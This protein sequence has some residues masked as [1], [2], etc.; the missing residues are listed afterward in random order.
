[1]P[2]LQRFLQSSAYLAFEEKLTRI[3]FKIMTKRFSSL[4]QAFLM[5]AL[6]SVCAVGCSEKDEPGIDNGSNGG[7]NSEI[8]FSLPSSVDVVVGED[9]RIDVANCPVLTSDQIYLEKD[10]KLIAC[11]VTEAD[12]THFCF[13]LPSTAEAATYTLYVKRGDRRVKI[14]T[15]V[16]NLVAYKIDIKEDT[17]I[18]GVVETKEGEGIPNVVV[19]DGEETTLTDANGVYQLKSNKGQGYVFISVPSGYECELNGVFPDHYRRLISGPSTPENHSFTLTKVN[20]SNYRVLFL[21]DMHLA[22]RCKGGTASNSD[23]TQFKYIAKDI[24]NYI[25]ANNKKTYLITLGDMTWDLYWYDCNYDLAEYK[26]TINEQLGGNMIFHTIGNHDNDMN[27]AGLAGAKGPFAVNIAPPYYSFNI[28]GTHYIIL[29]NINTSKYVAGGGKANRTDDIMECGKFYDSEIDWLKKD[30]SYVDKSTPLIVMMHVPLYNDA[31][32]AKFAP[33]VATYS[34]M[35]VDLLAGYKVHFVTGHTHRNYN[36][37]PTNSG[38]MSADVYEHNVGAIC[39]DWWWSGAKSPGYLMAPDGNPAGYAVWDIEGTNY[40]YLYKAAG[41]DEN[42]QF[43]SYDLNTLSYS[44]SDVEGGV[45][46]KMLSAFNSTIADYTNNRKNEVLINVWNYNTNWTIEV[47]TIDGKDLAVSHVSA[48]D[49]LHIKANVFKRWSNS[50]TSKPIGSTSKDHHFFKVTAPD[51]DTDLVITVKDEF[52]H[53]WT[54]TMER[55]KKIT[56]A[57]YR[58]SLN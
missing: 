18:Y 16:L 55:P 56:D 7:D 32:P 14:G 36:V 31:S 1:M 50:D 20:Q 41:K 3:N 19:S 42:F 23:N 26:K 58:I 40:Q 53:V 12:N 13:K 30:L 48:Y 34:Q 24:R 51:A 46:D 10:G 39:S 54:E 29:D 38:S 43:R 15:I 11:T 21:G 52:G 4:L 37:L 9:C 47:K 2:A 6:F 22:N 45:S 57:S 35:I 25:A 49:P 17:T 33:K 8:S 44:I 5:L 27:G 28:G